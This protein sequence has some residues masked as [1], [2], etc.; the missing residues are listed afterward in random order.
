MK[1]IFKKGDSVFAIIYGWGEITS[2]ESSEDDFYPIKVKFASGCR[3]YTMEGKEFIG[4]I[5]VLSFTKYTFDGFSQDR[6]WM[7][8]KGE[9]V[10]VADEDY[11]VWYICVFKEIKDGKFVT[12]GTY[13]NSGDLMWDKCKPFKI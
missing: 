2:I 7:P 11:E 8:E 12:Y 5:K 9:V 10:L 3:E 1:E 6:S 4:S 13:E